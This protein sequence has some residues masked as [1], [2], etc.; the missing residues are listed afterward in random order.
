MRRLPS[1]NLGLSGCV[2]SYR[3]SLAQRLDE[4]IVKGVVGVPGRGIRG[5]FFQTT[6]LP[7]LRLQCLSIGLSGSR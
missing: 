2:L 1:W 4:S 5:G 7:Q 6:R 3:R